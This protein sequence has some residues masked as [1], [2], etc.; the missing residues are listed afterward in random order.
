[1][2]FSSRP[3]ESL[4]S[5][6][7]L[8]NQLHLLSRDLGPQALEAGEPVEYPSVKALAELANSIENYS[9]DDPNAE[10]AGDI[11][12]KLRNLVSAVFIDMERFAKEG[13]RGYAMRLIN[14]LVDSMPEI[15]SELSAR[16]IRFTLLDVIGADTVADDLFKNTRHSLVS[17]Y[18]QVSKSNGEPATK[19]IKPAPHTKAEQ[20]QAKTELGMGKPEQAAIEA[21]QEAAR[22]EAAKL[23]GLRPSKL[24]DAKALGVFDIYDEPTSPADEPAPEP[25]GAPLDPDQDPETTNVFV[26][27]I[28]LLGAAAHSQANGLNDTEKRPSPVPQATVHSG[29]DMKEAVELAVKNGQDAFAITGNH[30]DYKLKV[31]N[32]APMPAPT[33]TPAPAPEQAVSPLPEPPSLKKDPLPATIANPDQYPDG[34]GPIPLPGGRPAPL[35]PLPLPAGIKLPSSYLPKSLEGSSSNGRILVRDI[36]DA[37]EKAEKPKKPLVTRMRAVIAA[38]VLG[39]L[40][41]GVVASALGRNTSEPKPGTISSAQLANTPAPK[42]EE[43]KKEEAP[44]KKE[45]KFETGFYRMDTSYAGYQNYMARYKKS[46][47]LVQNVENFSKEV[48]VLYRQDP[49]EVKK[50]RDEG[51]LVMTGA[52]TEEQQKIMMFEGLIEVSARKNYGK[53]NAVKDY[54]NNASKALANYKKTGVWDSVAIG[55][56]SKELFSIVGKPLKFK[57]SPNVAGYTFDNNPESNLALSKIKSSAP[58]YY[59]L[60]IQAGD[61]LKAETDPTKFSKFDDPATIKTFT[62]ARITA[63]AMTYKSADVTS[64]IAYMNGQW[65]KP[66]D[67]NPDNYLNQVVQKTIPKAADNQPASSVQPQAQPNQP[68]PQGTFLPNIAPQ[69]AQPNSAPVEAPKAKPGLWNKL[70]SIFSSEQKASE[71]VTKPVQPIMQQQKPVSN[72]IST[73]REDLYAKARKYRKIA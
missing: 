28:A 6:S 34:T 1:M 46:T 24:P 32:I 63:I 17:Y 71:P 55:Y 49:L 61:E 26:N 67:T 51:K 35:A 8:L 60:L 23:A 69:Q 13:K 65:C 54:F 50:L 62:C 38:S 42:P 56:G 39:V 58:T 12:T 44:E 59:K 47:G 20:R 37:P 27:P 33:S 11:T 57:D 31:P 14:A 66:N 21:A 15:E 3:P 41:L 4:K 72:T 73:S 45:T 5:G 2:S 10:L 52:E 18:S 7:N 48:R 68:A 9:S 19:T 53:N 36:T 30:P 43:A 40:G 29:R 16:Q 22:A 70:K 64:G 25:V